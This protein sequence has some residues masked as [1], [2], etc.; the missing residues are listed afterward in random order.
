MAYSGRY[1]VKN[2]S[3]Y[4]GDHTK[5]IYR[6]LWER[7][8]MRWCDDSA[9]VVQWSSEEVVI[10]YLYEVDRRYHRYFMD[11]KITL[12]CGKTLLVEVKPNKETTPPAGNKRTKRYISEA[13]TYVKNRNKWET[14]IEYAKDRGWEFQIWTE[15]ELSAKGILPKS[16]RPMKKLKPMPKYSRKKTK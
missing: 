5:V 12:K 15:K 9:D 6:S 14:A 11:F 1:K 16:T 3:K 2:S 13:M 7:N 8:V 4:Q 10:P